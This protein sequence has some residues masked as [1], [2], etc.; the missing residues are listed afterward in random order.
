TRR[1]GSKRC[2]VAL[3]W[4]APET[5]VEVW[6][7]GRL[8]RPAAGDATAFLRRRTLAS[9]RSWA[10]IG[11]PA[12][13]RRSTD[14][15]APPFPPHGPVRGRR[16]APPDGRLRHGPGTVHPEGSRRL[17]RVRGLLAGGQAAGHGRGGHRASPVG[18]GHG[19]TAGRR[20]AGRGSGLCLVGGLRAG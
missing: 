15:A 11:R 10:I 20:G 12:N 13:H 1:A 18:P 5:W 3:A 19:A 2:R 4:P 8:S 14:A 9:G 16:P 6:D 7:R 17:G